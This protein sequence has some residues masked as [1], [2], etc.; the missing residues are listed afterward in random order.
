MRA[1]GLWWR[2]KL[3]IVRKWVAAP[4]NV[5]AVTR[6]HTPITTVTNPRVLTNWAISSPPCMCLYVYVCVFVCVHTCVCVCVCLCERACMCV[7][8][9]DWLIGGFFTLCRHH[10]SYSCENC[11]FFIQPSLL[12]AIQ[13]H[14]QSICVSRHLRI[15][16]SHNVCYVFVC[17]CV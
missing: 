3:Y 17:A 1:T 5:M 13:K 14:T 6:I 15:L 7:N 9:C 16:K 8:E 10:R 4:L 12:H 11:L 2:C